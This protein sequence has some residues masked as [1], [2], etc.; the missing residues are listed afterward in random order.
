MK[1]LITFIIAFVFN[2][3]AFALEIT[4]YEAR[5]EPAKPLAKSHKV[6]AGD[7]VYA[8]AKKYKVS[9]S[10]LIKKN[11]LKAP[12][13]IEAGQVLKLPSAKR[14]FIKKKDTLYSL[15]RKFNVSVRDLASL[16]NITKNTKLQAGNYINI[17]NISFDK[18]NMV[19]APSPTKTAVKTKKEGAFSRKKVELRKVGNKPRPT[20]TASASPKKKAQQRRLKKIS[21]QTP[22]SNGKF[23]YPVRGKLISGFGKKETGVFNDG[24]NISAK[25]G[26][27]V[28]ASDNGVVVY[29]GSGLRAFGNM[30]LIKHDK[31]FVTVYAHL[32][33][34]HVKRG[35]VVK[36]RQ[37][38]GRVGST[39]RVKKAQLHFQIRKK[40]QVLNPRKYL[41]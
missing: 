22:K 10:S 2:V 27:K 11:N 1:K 6:M 39:G 31:K 26:T 14:Y 35:D 34:I 9:T 40:R 4:T 36:Q 24:I 3:N 7:N 19:K 21:K 33:K 28:V 32:D 20:K 41:R 23:I 37:V 13:Y 30:V 25:K 5:T 16:N 29:I 38:I 17:P 18:K 15:S 12:Y 8:I